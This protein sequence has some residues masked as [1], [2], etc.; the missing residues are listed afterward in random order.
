MKND[1]GSWLKTLCSNL[2]YACFCSGLRDVIVV[3]SSSLT[4]ICN[5]SLIYFNI[6]SS[7]FECLS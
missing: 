3:I 7:L 4:T 1:A 6:F 5:S 2:S